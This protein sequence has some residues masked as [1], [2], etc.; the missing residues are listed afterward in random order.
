MAPDNNI[1]KDRFKMNDEYII[2]MDRFK[3][4]N[5]YIIKKNRF[6]MTD[7]YITKIDRSKMAHE[8][9][10]YTILRRFDYIPRCLLHR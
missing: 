3:M 6:N 5:E 10:A 9:S 4:A 1:K 2:K 7:E 8:T